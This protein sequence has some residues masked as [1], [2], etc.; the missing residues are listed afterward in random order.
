MMNLQERV[1]KIRVAFSNRNYDVMRQEG[2]LE[3]EE[4]RHQ[5]RMEK[6]LKSVPSL[7]LGKSFDD[8]RVDYPEQD[9]VKKIAQRYAD[10]FKERLE[11]GN[12]LLFLGNPGTGKT[13]LSLILYQTLAKS[14]FIV[15]Y[16]PSLHF[17]RLFRDKSFESHQAFEKILDY[18]TRMEFL[19][20]DEATES[21]V[22]GNDLCH[23]EKENLFS[24]VNSRYQQSKLCTLFISNLSEKEVEKKIGERI[25]GRL[26]QDSISLSFNWQ[27]YRQ[28]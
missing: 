15:H 11:N 3:I 6:F 13:L 4:K 5:D 25:M 19:I 2:I 26:M 24:L 8:F 23:W 1:E 20:I 12:N 21:R 10:S 27:S 28:P 22:T 14:G 9:R 7:F 18:Y 17:L 16:E